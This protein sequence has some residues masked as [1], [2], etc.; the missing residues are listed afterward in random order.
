[1]VKVGDWVKVHPDADGGEGVPPFAVRVRV[2]RDSGTVSVE[3][4]AD[5][6]CDV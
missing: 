6:Y 4:D 2:V 5:E 1:M 3:T